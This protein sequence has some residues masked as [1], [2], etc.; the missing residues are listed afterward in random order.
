MCCTSFHKLI[1][2]KNIQLNTTFTSLRLFILKSFY[3]KIT[4]IIN[5]IAFIK[6]IKEVEKIHKYLDNS[7]FDLKI[8]FKKKRR[9]KNYY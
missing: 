2:T 4:F 5:P 7:K 6:G 9:S 3:E 8:T 1:V